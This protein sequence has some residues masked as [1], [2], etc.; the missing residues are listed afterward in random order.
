MTKVSGQF[1]SL[2]HISISTGTI[3]V[4]AMAA[5]PGYVL[6]AGSYCSALIR[7]SLATRL[8]YMGD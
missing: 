5:G 3:P 2:F 7:A 4:T 6:S 8:L 1:R